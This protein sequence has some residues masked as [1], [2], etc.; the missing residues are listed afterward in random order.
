MFIPSFEVKK[1]KNCADLPFSH[2]L[3]LQ[4]WCQPRSSMLQRWGWDEAEP[5]SYFAIDR[6]C[7]DTAFKAG[8]RLLAVRS[9]VVLP[10]PWL[11][12]LLEFPSFLSNSS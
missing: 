7:K 6:C 8:G 4:V 10:H 11:L 3:A 12:A 2:V 5:V 9:T 1:Q